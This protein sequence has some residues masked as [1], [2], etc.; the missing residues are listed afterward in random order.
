MP[1]LKIV[2]GSRLITFLQS[3]GFIMLRQSGS[4]VILQKNDKTVVVPLYKGKDL[5]GGLISSILK[6][7]DISLISYQKEV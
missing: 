5:G 7:S 6:D 2:T 1:K 4:H 3:H